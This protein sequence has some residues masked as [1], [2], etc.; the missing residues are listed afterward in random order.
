[1]NFPQE[2]CILFGGKGWCVLSCMKN[3]CNVVGRSMI[4]L[5]SYLE[6]VILSDG[7]RCQVDKGWII[8]VF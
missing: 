3:S 7:C 6:I 5:V 4:L 8:M 2:L 1:M